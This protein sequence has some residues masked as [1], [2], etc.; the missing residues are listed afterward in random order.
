MS[1][2]I[3]SIIYLC[4]DSTN[5]Y[6]EGSMKSMSSVSEECSSHKI[7]Q[8]FSIL[9]HRQLTNI[10]PIIRPKGIRNKKYNTSINNR[11]A[12][13]DWNCDCD[14][15]DCNCNCFACDA[16]CICD[17]VPNVCECFDCTKR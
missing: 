16:N 12:S 4:S 6:L 9:N 11:M 2:V 13:A 10:Y 8:L 1:N 15:N 5:L 14:I 3:V 17:C 7:Q